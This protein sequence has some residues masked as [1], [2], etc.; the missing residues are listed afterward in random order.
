M[1]EPAYIAISAAKKKSLLEAIPAE[2]HVVVPADT[3][4]LTKF[5]ET[6]GVLTPREIEITAAYDAVALLERV[7]AGKYTSL[8]VAVAF[9]KRAAIAH[10]AINCCT[11]IFFERAYEVAKKQDEYFVANGKPMGPLHGLPVSI[12]DSYNLRGIDSAIGMP[13]WVGRPEPESSA[14]V[15]VLEELGAVMYVKTT[16]PQSMM[17][18]DTANN[19]IGA[20]RNPFSAHITAAG[21]SGGAGA[22]VAFRGSLI[23]MATDIGGS[24]RVPAYCNGQYGFKPSSGRLP[25][26]NI[27]G[28]W[29]DG[30]DVTGVL[31]VDGP[32]TTSARDLELIVGSIARSK[33]W[34][35]DPSCARLPWVDE[36]IDRPLRIG[37]ISSVKTYEPITSIFAECQA[38]LVAAGH[39]LVPVDFIL[40]NEL[41]DIA[42]AFYKADG[43]EFLVKVCAESGEPL[44]QAVAEGGLYPC[45]PIGLHAFWKL[46]HERAAMQRKWLLHWQAT[47]SK[48]ASGEPVDVL[49][50]PAQPQLPR[51][52]E[53]LTSNTVILAWNTLDYPAAIFP[54]ETID[55]ARKSYAFEFPAPVTDAEKRADALFPA[56]RA[57]AYDGF[58]VGLQLV[59]QKQDD[60]ALCR[61]VSIVC[62]VLEK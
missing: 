30:E 37:V 35:V 22:I 19:L 9:C 27:K 10:Q 33:P 54:A 47:A 8:E 34:L 2:W 58:P 38:K 59:G 42:T 1:V 48:T 62:G 7:H 5:A 40:E 49:L 55:L 41:S 46:S 39:E 17:V 32:V 13:A 11:E 31:C 28:Y 3:D 20:A 60:A 18:L 43:G 14:I 50:M 52:K 15:E 21:S 45:E 4:N 12:K 26:H 16:V 24:I 56:D 53:P 36:P 23:G 6:C 25:Y 61:A 29:P 57:A 51:P 44:T